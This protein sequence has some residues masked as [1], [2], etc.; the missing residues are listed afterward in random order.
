MLNPLTAE[1]KKA[2][3]DRH[4]PL[5]KLNWRLEKNMSTDCILNYVVNSACSSR[6]TA[7][8]LNKKSEAVAS[9]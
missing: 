3:D 7:I 5:Y 6:H 4:A 2:I 8:S 1:I 9:L